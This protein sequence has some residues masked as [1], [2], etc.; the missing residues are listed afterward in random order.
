MQYVTSR[1][2][3]IPHSTKHYKP[4]VAARDEGLGSGFDSKEC[5]VPMM[6]GDDDLSDQ[7]DPSLETSKST[8]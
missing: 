4:G 5:D 3:K 1:W 8:S 2:S 6:T 7:K